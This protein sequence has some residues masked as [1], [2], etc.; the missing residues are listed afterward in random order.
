M[1]RVV[2]ALLLIKEGGTLYSDVHGTCVKLAR[3]L[4]LFQYTYCVMYGYVCFL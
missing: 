4:C 3:P 1:N 2:R